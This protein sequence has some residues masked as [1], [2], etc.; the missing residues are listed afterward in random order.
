MPNEQVLVKPLSSDE[1]L[2]I[3]IN[4]LRQA[5]EKNCL[6]ARHLAY[7]TFRFKAH[8]EINFQTTGILTEAT[9]DAG[10]QEGSV[11]A[12]IPEDSVVLDFEEEEKPPNQLRQENDMPVTV[13]R[14]APGGK[15]VEEKVHYTDPKFVRKAGKKK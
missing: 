11:D 4:K 9:L 7:S 6:L 15:M 1:I 14:K 13:A 12:E 5:K 2:E 10:G 3:I 8:V